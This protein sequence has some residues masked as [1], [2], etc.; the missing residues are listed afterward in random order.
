M[1]DA[2]VPTH[3]MRRIQVFSAHSP[4]NT[5][6]NFVPFTDPTSRN[7]SIINNLAVRFAVPPPDRTALAVQQTVEGMFN[8]GDMPR[9][10][11][12]QKGLILF[13]LL[14]ALATP[15]AEMGGPVSR[16]SPATRDL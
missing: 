15:A 16:L 10:Q 13:H 7:A 8:L 1:V 4:W 9:L 12:E 5:P 2:V 6:M 3:G 11:D 14:R